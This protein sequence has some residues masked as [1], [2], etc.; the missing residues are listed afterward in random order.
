[1]RNQSVTR[2]EISRIIQADRYATIEQGKC[3]NPRLEFIDAAQGLS[4]LP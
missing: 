4:L 2:Y 3:Y 1:M